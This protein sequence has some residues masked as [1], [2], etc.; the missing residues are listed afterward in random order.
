MIDLVDSA[1]D[2]FL[3]RIKN[4][5]D[6]I[7]QPYLPDQNDIPLHAPSHSHNMILI[8]KT[9]FLKV[10]DFIIHPYALQIFL[11][12][13]LFLL[14]VVCSVCQ[15]LLN[16]WMN[17]WMANLHMSVSNQLL[18]EFRSVKLGSKCDCHRRVALRFT[19]PPLMGG[20]SC[21]IFLSLTKMR[22]LINIDARCC[23]ETET[24]SGGSPL[25]RLTSELA[26][27]R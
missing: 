8:N 10:I 3:F 24:E 19:Q 17:E 14:F 26:S 18:V 7:L 6:H 27:E 20:L 23:S 25:C 9:K 21:I 11:L 1:G 22:L 4:N 16:E 5:P 12:T 15:P 2:Y 13:F